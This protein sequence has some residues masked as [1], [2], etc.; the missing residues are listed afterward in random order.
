MQIITSNL[1]VAVIGNLGES[2]NASA[3]PS[4]LE[5]KVSSRLTSMCTFSSSKSI[6]HVLGLHQWS[7][8]CRSCAGGHQGQLHVPD[9][10]HMVDLPH[11]Y[12]YCSTIP[13]SSAMGALLCL[14]PLHHG[15]HLQYVS[16]EGCSAHRCVH[17]LPD[18]DPPVPRLPLDKPRRSR[19]HCSENRQTARR[20][21]RFER[22]PLRESSAV[23]CN[24]FLGIV[25]FMSVVTRGQS[26]SS[27]CNPSAAS[28]REIL[29]CWE[30]SEPSFGVRLLLY[31][32]VLASF[33]PMP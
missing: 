1:T 22:G 27:F 16:G 24:Y 10:G 25:S 20:M 33:V 11:L 23:S 21:P 3:Y 7:K 2:M 32:E 6:P 13:A 15:H 8:K 30:D 9:E 14:Y 4:L 29:V 17:N 18:S 31:R 5:M 12:R 26:S 28:F 19:W